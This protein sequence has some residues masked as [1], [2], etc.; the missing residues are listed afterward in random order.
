MV[1][2]HRIFFCD[3]L[4]ESQFGKFNLIG[5]NRSGIITIDKIP[6][7]LQT[8]L[9]LEGIYRKSHNS[10]L[11]VTILLK[12]LSDENLSEN[13]VEIKTPPKI[14]NDIPLIV[15]IKCHLIIEEY[16]AVE[17]NILED[18]KPIFKE[19]FKIVQGV[20]P[21]IR[22]TEKFDSSGLFIPGRNNFNLKSI[23][24]SA[25]RELILID[26]YIEPDTFIKIVSMTPPNAVVKALVRH[27][28]M[29]DYNQEIDKIKTLPN[30]VEI[31]F[32]SAFHDRFIIVN[33]T[34]FYHFGH[35][36]KDL[37]KGK[38]SRYDKMIRKNEVY[39]LKDKFDDI[40]SKA[41]LLLD[42]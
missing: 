9:I 33:N 40:W 22:I 19:S 6:Y 18:T 8:T 16:G 38:V 3:E 7:T 31:K 1:S 37:T 32:S 13:T 26:Q 30:K 5:Y 10:N 23:V 35:S 36:L 29:S 34:E 2:I 41:E 12:N 15:P 11:S 28:L 42:C 25:S 14:R 17:I 39:E 27:K 20:A 24:G 4:S 21:N